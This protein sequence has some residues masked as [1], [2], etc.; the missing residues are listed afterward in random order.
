MDAR[1]LVVAAGAACLTSCMIQV[2]HGPMRHEYAEFDRENVERLHVDLRMGAGEL[3]V[4]GGSGKLARADFTYD[5]DAWKPD[6][7]FH[8]TGESRDLT[9]KQ[10]GSHRSS[11]GDTTYRWDVQLA[12]SVGMELTANLGAGESRMDLG[13]LDLRR[14]EVEMGVGELQMDL[15][16]TPKH[17][18]TVRVRGGVGEATIHFPR[19]VG[20]YATG[21]GGIGEIHTE[22]LRKQGDH[23]V[24]DA[25]NDAKVRIHVDVQGGIGQINLISN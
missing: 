4:R 14:V 6:V 11:L 9:I 18:Y 13:A 21:E 25:Y 19:D 10:P 20:V 16:G 24:N 22:G 1:W 15:R 5:V 3:R 7:V 8:G 2:S 23:W 17:D 12:N